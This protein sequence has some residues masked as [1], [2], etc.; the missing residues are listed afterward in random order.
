MKRR[1]KNDVIFPHMGGDLVSERHRAQCSTVCSLHGSVSGFHPF[2]NAA[3]SS[4]Y[5][6]FLVP[7]LPLS[8]RL[9]LCS[10]AIPDVLI[11]LSLFSPRFTAANSSCFP[12]DTLS[13]RFSCKSIL[14]FATGKLLSS[15]LFPTASARP[16]LYHNQLTARP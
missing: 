1:P 12:Q 11:Q 14:L 3:P 15:R 10:P 9:V 7:R 2:A 6:L 16:C 4:A 5:C 8:S 13:L